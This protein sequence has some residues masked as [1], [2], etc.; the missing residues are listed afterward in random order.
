ML[1]D[2]LLPGAAATY[3]R[4]LVTHLPATAFHG[5]ESHQPP[6]GHG[7]SCCRAPQCMRQR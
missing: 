2:V 7:H 3:T 6:S 5:H 4:H 1:L